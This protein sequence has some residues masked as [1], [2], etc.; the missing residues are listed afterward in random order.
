MSEAA[1]GA[2]GECPSGDI[3]AYLDGEL[4]AGGVDALEA[5]IASCPAC[6]NELNAQKAFLLEL[7]RSLEA[8]TAVDVPRNFA[9][10]IVTK[11]E[12]G[13]SGL[14]ER[15]ERKT[16]AAVVI[17]LVALAGASVAGDWAL[18]GAEAA[19]P[20]NYLGAVFEAGAGVLRN[21]LFA[22]SFV[23]KKTVS[24]PA[25]A[26]LTILILISVLA[27]ALWMRRRRTVG[28]Q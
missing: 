26:L 25:A 7:S 17:L 14:R 9:R 13:V 6:L 27:A 11:A 8:G 24:G 12:S 10:A 20:L 5:H 22:L 16:A 1:S 23:L 21:T 15:S 3:G 28:T 18:I 4:P 19:R 2:Q